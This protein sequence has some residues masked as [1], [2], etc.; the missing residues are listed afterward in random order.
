MSKLMHMVSETVYGPDGQTVTY[1]A[2][3]LHDP[4][5]LPAGVPYRE[6]VASDEFAATAPE[7]AGKAAK[8]EAKPAAAAAKAAKA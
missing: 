4:G 5:S 6:V 1:G 2:G 8:A 7:H 3:E